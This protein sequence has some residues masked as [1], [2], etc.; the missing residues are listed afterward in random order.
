MSFTW[1]Q[2]RQSDPLPRVFISTHFPLANTSWANH[3]QL[4]PSNTLLCHWL[5]GK[6]ERET[7][8]CFRGFI[9]NP[10]HSLK[11]L[12]TTHSQLTKIPQGG[13]YRWEL[14]SVNQWFS[15]QAAKLKSTIY[16]LSY[17]VGEV[18]PMFDG[19]SH[20]SC[21]M[22]EEVKCT[23]EQDFKTS[24][25]K[26]HIHQFQFSNF[27]FFFCDPPNV[28]PASI[29]SCTVLPTKKTHDQK[30]DR[31]DTTWIQS[32]SQANNKYTNL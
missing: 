16:Y 30:L 3:I 10:L 21:L 12:P 31:L 22:N 20:S 23:M 32:S 6:W 18:S 17:L 27:L 29:S 7:S 8:K 1:Q 15:E 24:N 2:H 26:I 14:D 25:C 4:Y 19:L 11:H 13:K 28:I 5:G 9:L